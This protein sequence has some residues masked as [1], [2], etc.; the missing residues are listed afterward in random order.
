MKH[1]LNIP[2]ISNLEKKYVLD[3]LKKNWLSINGIHNKIA[4]KK[5]SKLVNKK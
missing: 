1:L 3:V 2:N 4:E 5:F